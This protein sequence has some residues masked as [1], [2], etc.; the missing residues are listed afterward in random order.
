MDF[1]G[2]GWEDPKSQAIMALSAGLLRRDF[3]GGLLAANDAY[4]QAKKVKS[5][6]EFDK[7]RIQE[8]RMK[9]EDAQ[10]ARDFR[11]SIPSPEFLAGTQGLLG[12]GGPTLEN[13]ARIPAVSPM[14]SLL[15][16]GA[17]AGAFGMDDYLKAMQPKQLEFG[18]IDPKDYTQDSLRAAQSTGDYTKLVPVRKMD[19]VGNRAVNL[20]DT[21]PGTVMDN[22]D[23]NQPF[24]I[25]GG[26]VTANTPFQQ[27]SMN[28]A[29]AGAANVSV[30]TGQKGL[31][32]E[33][34]IRSDFRSEPI[35]K[36]HNEVQ[37]AYQQITTSL[38]QASPAGDLAG[39]TKIMKILDPGS[40]VRESEL[41]MAMAATGA[42]DRLYNYAGM[43]VNGTKLTPKQRADFQNLADKL[44]DESAKQ[45]NAKRGE[46]AGFATDYGL[47]A[48]RI[49]GPAITSP[50]RIAP[51]AA[52]GSTGQPGT[53]S[54]E[55]LLKKY[56]G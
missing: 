49:V 34:K 19:V 4:A 33:L 23:P 2:N 18:K 28:K 40:V 26:Q 16:R 39:A 10:K 1:F 53:R 47:N 36:A 21:A 31:D 8:A 25:V 7:L 45:Y 46:Y 32:N 52:P 41:G 15:H 14:Q 29:K 30:N 38:K 51:S 22:I 56:G 48:D 12:G 6:E 35:Y 24:N 13:A 11:S 37:S 44:Y 3:G 27:F 20:Y 54:I 9:M 55:D 43:V 17:Q 42:L 50:K 5:I